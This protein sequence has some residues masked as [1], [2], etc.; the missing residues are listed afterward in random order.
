MQSNIVGL[1]YLVNY[2][3]ILTCWARS[4]VGRASVLHTEGQEFE[5]PRV[6]HEKIATLCGDFFMA[7]SWIGD[8]NWEGVGEQ[9]FPV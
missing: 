7:W 6:H 3:N 8:S 1:K 2:V 4:L 5:S 9:E